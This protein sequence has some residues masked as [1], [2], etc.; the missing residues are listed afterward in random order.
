MPAAIPPDVS[1]MLT[2]AIV[3]LM[4]AAYFALHIP[5]C[6]HSECKAAHLAAEARAALAQRAELAERTHSIYH[7]P[8]RPQANCVL[9]QSRKRDES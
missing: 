5:R 6:D 3:S 8:L 9:C 7:D 2:V 1:A 4:A